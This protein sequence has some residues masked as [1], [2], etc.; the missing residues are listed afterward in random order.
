ML[1]RNCVKK[2]WLENPRSLPPCMPSAVSGP[3][4]EFGCSTVKIEGMNDARNRK[5]E[6]KS[7]A[8]SEQIS[9]LLHCTL[10]SRLGYWVN[11]IAP[12]RLTLGLKSQSLLC[13]SF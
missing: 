11:S 9:T 7:T 4:E 2:D 8:K 1:V 3:R 5:W 12:V 10:L 13:G 6:E